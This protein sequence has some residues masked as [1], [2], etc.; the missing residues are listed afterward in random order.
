[1]SALPCAT[2][3]PCIQ[4]TSKSDELASVYFRNFVGGGM[5]RTQVRRV[6]AYV[7]S[8]I[9]AVRAVRHKWADGPGAMPM[10]IENP[11]YRSGLRSV[12]LGPA[13]QL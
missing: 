7:A 6:S 9:G 3:L 12:P 10:P 13:S 8:T 4:S 2:L 5:L 1:M 11:L